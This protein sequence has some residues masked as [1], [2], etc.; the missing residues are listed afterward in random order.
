MADNLHTFIY[1]VKGNVN[2]HSSARIATQ[3]HRS[4]PGALRLTRMVDYFYLHCVF[5]EEKTKNNKKH[6]VG[7]I[8]CCH[9]KNIRM[10]CSRI[11]VFCVH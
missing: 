7:Q 1:E 10:T 11:H 9:S 8:D 6:K 2:W 3:A 4:K 5:D